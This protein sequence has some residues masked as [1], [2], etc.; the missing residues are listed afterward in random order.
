MFSVKFEIAGECYSRTRGSNWAHR[1][2][3][4][5]GKHPSNSVKP[6]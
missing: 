6:L 3:M 4:I 1:T 2:V 5:Y